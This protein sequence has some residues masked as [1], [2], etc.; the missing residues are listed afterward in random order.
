MAK[1]NSY[2]HVK[3]FL[4][5]YIYRRNKTEYD[6]GRKRKKILIIKLIRNLFVEVWYFQMA[7]MISI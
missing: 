6:S 3:K 7:S 4:E 5:I 2:S 1:P